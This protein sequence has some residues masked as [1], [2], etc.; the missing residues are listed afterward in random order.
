MF[1]RLN[2]GKRMADACNRMPCGLNHAVDAIK[3]HQRLR[4]IGNAGFARLIR[5]REGRG[6]IGLGSPMN[7]REGGFGLADIKIRN[8]H[9]VIALDVLCLR[10]DH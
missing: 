4:V 6:V 8:T 3:F 9:N 2:G 5:V 1:A 7:A 10:E